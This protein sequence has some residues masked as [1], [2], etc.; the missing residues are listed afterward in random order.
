MACSLS[1][2]TNSWPV[3]SYHIEVYVNENLTTKVK[4]AIKAAT[5]RKSKDESEEESSEQE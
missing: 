5:V 2:P 1:K 4:F 3:G